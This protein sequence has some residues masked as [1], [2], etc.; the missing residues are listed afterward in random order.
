MEDKKNKIKKDEI[1]DVAWNL[2]SKTGIV[3]HY[4]FYKEIGKK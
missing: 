2:F 1:Q 4:L 3:S